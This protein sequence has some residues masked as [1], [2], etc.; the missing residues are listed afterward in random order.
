M[1][2]IGLV[3]VAPLPLLGP[4]YMSL[5]DRLEV[6]LQ[7]EAHEDVHCILDVADH[8]QWVRLEEPA[9]FLLVLSDIELGLGLEFLETALPG[10]GLVQLDL[11]LD[12][13]VQVNDAEGEG[14]QGVLEHLFALDAL[15]DLLGRT[16]LRR[17][18]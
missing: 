16:C 5:L 11:V 17:N 18:R 1:V 9:A 2:L 15:V 6:V 3:V 4:V 8:D 10:E 14:L 12:G 13:L 7:F